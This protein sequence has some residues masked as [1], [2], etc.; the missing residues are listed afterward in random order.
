MNDDARTPDPREAKLP[1]WTQRLLDELRSELTHAIEESDRAKAAA[2]TLSGQTDP[3]GCP[4][5]ALLPDGETLGLPADVIIQVKPLDIDVSWDDTDVIVEA[6]TGTG[7]I[8]VAPWTNYSI[9]VFRS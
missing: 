2:A 4:I 7:Q 3:A 5:V 8:A 1:A 9:K 6:G